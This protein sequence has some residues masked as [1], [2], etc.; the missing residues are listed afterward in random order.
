ME[1][2]SQTA[3]PRSRTSVLREFTP[4]R[5]HYIIPLCWIAYLGVEKFRIAVRGFRSS[6]IDLSRPSARPLP[7]PTFLPWLR[8]PIFAYVEAG[9]GSARHRRSRMFFPRR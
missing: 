1:N 4:S 9:T 6:G 8:Q 2:L 5:P 3:E 7:F